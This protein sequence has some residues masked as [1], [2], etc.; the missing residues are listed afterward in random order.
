[1]ARQNELSVNAILAVER[2]RVKPKLWTPHDL[3]EH[4]L[5]NVNW[6]YRR[7]SEGAA[8]RIPHIRMGKLLRF[9]TFGL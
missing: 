6:I 7:T 8:D 2:E 5:V 4:L 9:D 3:T 1:M